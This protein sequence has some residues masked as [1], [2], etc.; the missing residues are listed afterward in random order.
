MFLSLKKYSCTSVHGVTLVKDQCILG[1]TKYSFS[2]RTIN[3]WNNLPTDCVT[4]SGMNM[5]IFKKQG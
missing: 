2:Q 3:E 5:N 1:I 4:A